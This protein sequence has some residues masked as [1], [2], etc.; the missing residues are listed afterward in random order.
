M[1]SS[2][3]LALTLGAGLGGIGGVVGDA[4]L[5]GSAFGGSFFIIGGAGGGVV[6]VA[7][8]TVSAGP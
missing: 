4:G 3:A 2:T 8:E 1:S 7:D 5:A 6:P